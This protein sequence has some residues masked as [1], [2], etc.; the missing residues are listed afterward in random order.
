M[1]LAVILSSNGANALDS[2]TVYL[3]DGASGKMALKV[4]DTGLGVGQN[5][6]RKFYRVD[7]HVGRDGQTKAVEQ[8]LFPADGLDSREL[9]DFVA[10]TSR[11][12]KEN[13]VAGKMVGCA[14]IILGGLVTYHWGVVAAA[15][16][17][18]LEFALLPGFAALTTMGLART[19]RSAEQVSREIVNA[20][21]CGVGADGVVDVSGRVAGLPAG[22][23]VLQICKP[24][25]RIDETTLGE[26]GKMGPFE[27]A[28]VRLVS[29]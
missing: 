7:F 12:A 27:T 10:L 16:K 25:F 19:Y 1:F 17:G 9:A 11:R 24:G 29:R 13:H 4:E 3:M 18:I 5:F 20:T 28:L 26:P 22:A 8:S 14:S 15:A 23:R 21:T 2:R 6:R